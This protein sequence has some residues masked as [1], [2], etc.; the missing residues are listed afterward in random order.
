[1]QQSKRNNRVYI[2]YNLALVRLLCDKVFTEQVFL[3]YCTSFSVE[4]TSAL[5]RLVLALK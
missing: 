3:K 2:A 1:V 5:K 4:K